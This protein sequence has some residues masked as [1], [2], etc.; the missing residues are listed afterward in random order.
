[1]KKIVLFLLAIS[2]MTCF[3]ACGSDKKDKDVN[4]NV[5]E[6][7]E[8][9]VEEELTPSEGLEFIS[10][11]DGTCT[12]VGIGTCTD[13]EIVVP[14]KNGDETVTVIGQG[15][16]VIGHSEV[17]V[18]KVIVPGTVTTIKEFA[19]ADAPFLKEVVLLE[20]VELIEKY[21]FYDCKYLTHILFPNTLKFIGEWAFGGCISLRE[22][23]LPEGLSELETFAFDDCSSVKKIYIPSTINKLSFISEKGGSCGFHFDM[24]KVEEFNFADEW[25]YAYIDIYTQ[26]YD[27]SGDKAFYFYGYLARDISNEDYPG[28]F[29]ELTDANKEKIICALLGKDSLMVNGEEY[30]FENKQPE[31]YYEVQGFY[32]FTLNEYTAGDNLNVSYVQAKKE[33]NVENIVSGPYIYNEELNIFEF[34][35]NT[36]LEG[37]DIT[38][39]KHFMNFGDFIISRELHT[40]NGVN[41]RV[42]YWK[43]V[44]YSSNLD[45]FVEEDVEN[46]EKEELDVIIE[47]KNDL[48]AELIAAFNKE[49]ITVS[50]DEL[51]GE[52]AMDA[53]VLFGGDSSE[54]SAEGKEF[55]N[56]FVKAYTS[57]IYSEKF[58]GF[59]SNTVVEGHTAL[60]PGSTYESG[61]PLSQERADKVMAYC[62][63]SEVDADTSKLSQAIEAVGCSNSK[64]IYT[65]QGAVNKE[66]SRR[67]SFRF[68]LNLEQN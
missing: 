32:G 18:A 61:L 51:T 27:Y 16:R 57:V 13:T 56:K 17:N 11:G 28:R 21:A 53:S 12:W 63:S 45:I 43:W 4:S 26:E 67:V 49:G 34:C 50:V 25:K 54:L 10:N 66:A 52:L 30:V 37:S 46:M 5:V 64:P 48:L 47:K 31:G 42:W 15:E 29:V 60:L 23:N 20:G 68:I 1:M 8:E 7:I 65:S 22:I 6:V 40:V 35:E 55:L 39:E 19:F 58:D 3:C 14:E 9:V 2:L 24:T 38:V 41:D 33:N 62:I 59:V 44:P 36:T